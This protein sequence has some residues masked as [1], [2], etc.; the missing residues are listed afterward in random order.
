MIRKLVLAAGLLSSMAASLQASPGCD[1][2]PGPLYA[3]YP[4]LNLSDDYFPSVV[5]DGNRFQNKGA[6]Y[7]YKMWHQ[8]PSGISLSYSNDG[9][10][11][12]FQSQV[13]ED[14]SAVHPV[15]IFD[16]N[17]FGGT[18]YFYRMWYW[19]QNSTPTPPNLSMNFTQSKDGVNWTTPVAVTQVTSSFL[20]NPETIS[21]PFRE[22]YGFSTV[23]HNPNPTSMRSDPFSFRY[24]AFYD[25]GAMQTAP[26]NYQQG[27]AI[28]FS[29]DGILWER[30][31][32]APVLAPSGNLTKWDGLY[33]THASVVRVHNQ[34]HMYYTGSNGDPSTGLFYA[35]GIG[36]AVS[37]NGIS[38]IR[39]SNPMIQTTDGVSW[40]N[41]HVQAPC[42]VAGSGNRIKVWFSGGNSSSGVS[43]LDKQIGYINGN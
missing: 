18:Q 43:P 1:E 5:Y 33:T 17:G 14:T 30:Y 35:H 42:A 31:G 32:T 25:M 13:L 28:A 37:S 21:T 6:S 20:N 38:W 4:S 12:Y 15:V 8:G 23:I 29:Y 24:T 34:Y 16:K 36:H 26:Y 27:I 3:P 7:Y 39:D 9:I 10:E 19:T 41:D 2:T 40:R 11:W 22:F